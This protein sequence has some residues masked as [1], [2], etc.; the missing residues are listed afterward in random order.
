MAN[1]RI[2]FLGTPEISAKLLE[3]LIKNNFNIVGVVTKEDKIRG[4]GN[5]IEP[6]PVALVADKYHIPVHKPHRLNTDYQFIEDLKPDLLL[7][8]AYGQ[9]I[10]EDILTLSRYKPLNLH[11]SILP[12]YR[13]AAPIQYA[14][15]NGDDITGVS[16]MEMVKEMD[17]GDVYAIEYI[18]IFMTDNYTSLSQKVA[19]AAL[20]LA[21]NKLPE[22]FKGN[23]KPTK[24]NEKKVTFSPSIKKEEEHLNLNASPIDFINQ[25]RSLSYKPGGYLFLND[26]ILK[27]YQAEYYS[28]KVESEVGK[29]VL[30][31]KKKIIL[32]LSKGQVNLLELQ[33]PGK[34]MMDS[35][36]F[37][38]GNKI[39]GII[40]K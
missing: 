4:R 9:I 32:Q 15:K 22:Y 35:N 17:A 36:N 2:I 40:L 26:E 3:G 27:I 5:K 21:V 24:Q 31:K 7:T 11:A 16:L 25:V 12:K 37:N 19:D 39:E 38:N 30:A 29:I 18:P 10:K 34:K 14:L 8:F 23:L 33:K 6:S 1:E 20:F 28:D 13:G